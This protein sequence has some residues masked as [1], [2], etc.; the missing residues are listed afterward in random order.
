MFLK[1]MTVCVNKRVADSQHDLKVSPL[2]LVR[3][4]RFTTTESADE[5]EFLALQ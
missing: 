3:V 5:Y 4:T 2:H 1:K